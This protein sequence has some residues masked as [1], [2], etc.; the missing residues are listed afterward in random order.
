M[1]FDLD[2][3]S[4]LTLTERVDFSDD[5]AVF[6]LRAPEPVDFTPG[7]YA[8]LG[9]M[10]EETERPLLRP[11]SVASRPGTKEL[12]FFIERVE[13]G[14]LSPKF[15]DLEPG[16]EVWMREKLVG[17]FVLDTNRRLINSL[18]SMGGVVDKEYALFEKPLAT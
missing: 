5:L 14:D 2:G 15:W 6:H 7:Q 10:N 12:E 11:Y 4:A 16:A 9:L 3:Y 18:E 17:R 8:T 1:A 13:D